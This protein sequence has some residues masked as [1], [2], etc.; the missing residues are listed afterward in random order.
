MILPPQVP[1]QPR[2]PVRFT[3]PYVSSTSL[4]QCCQT[5]DG[6]L[7]LVSFDVLNSTIRDPSAVFPYSLG[8]FP[9]SDYTFE[10]FNTN[11]E[12]FDMMYD[13]TKSGWLAAYLFETMD[14]SANKYV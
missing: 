7:G 6:F 14:F 8:D 13:T 12:L 4:G 5:K 10:R 9:S 1:F 11:D 3:I 2:D